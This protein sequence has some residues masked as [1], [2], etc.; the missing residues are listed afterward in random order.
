MRIGNMEWIPDDGVR[1]ISEEGANNSKTQL[2]LEEYEAIAQA[3]QT[4]MN[5]LKKSFR[6]WQNS[7]LGRDEQF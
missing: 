5:K 6:K 3:K 1:K 7:Q 4:N 2:Q